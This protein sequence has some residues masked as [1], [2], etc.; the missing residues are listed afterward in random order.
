[1]SLQIFDMLDESVLIVTD[2]LVS[3][4]DGA[5]VHFRH[6]VWPLP[7]L[8]AVMTVTGTAEIGVMWHALISELAGLDSIDDLDAVAREQLPRIYEHIRAHVAGDIGTATVTHFGF[9]RGSDTIVSDVYGLGPEQFQASRTR[10]NGERLFAVK[11]KPCSFKIEALPT[12]PE[13]IEDLA[14]KLQAEND[15]GLTPVRIAMGGDLIATLFRNHSIHTMRWARFP[16]Y[17]ASRSAM[18][19]RPFR[20][21]E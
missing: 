20:E 18:I 8:N 10:A 16:N 1:M 17:D 11:P 5:A 3:D 2:T 6:K 21:Q 19:G 14:L 7:H 9:P 13:E 12:T 15:E 4:A